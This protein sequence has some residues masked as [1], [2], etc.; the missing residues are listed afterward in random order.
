VVVSAG[1]GEE[2]LARRVAALAGLPPA[3]VLTGLSFDALSAL[4]AHARAVVVG[5]TGVA[6][7]AT[8][9]GTAS[10]VL[11]GPV[12]PRLWGP[13]LSP[14]H[15]VLWHPDTGPDPA[16]A[17]VRPGDPHADHPDARL[18][19]I[20]VEEVLTAVEEVLT[21]PARQPEPPARPG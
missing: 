9:H 17:P 4:V 14:A 3:A 19:R 1:P 18:L 6:H 16:T 11:F 21:A 13:P 15:R 2:R 20:G 5:D 8:A 10:V 12:S 7:L